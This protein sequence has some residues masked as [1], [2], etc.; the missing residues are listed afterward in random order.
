MSDR[1]SRNEIILLSV[2]ALCIV[3]LLCFVPF[4][5]YPVVECDCGHEGSE[6]ELFEDPEEFETAAGRKVRKVWFSPGTV[7]GLTQEDF[8]R[9]VMNGIRET[10][11]FTNTDFVQVPSQSGSWLRVY[12]ETDSA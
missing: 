1:L 10:S 12:T 3:V 2:F 6:F 7:A 5:A 11:A 4:C 8:Q 9:R